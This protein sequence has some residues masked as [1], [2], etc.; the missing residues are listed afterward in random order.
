MR[1]TH[2][3][4]SRFLVAVLIALLLGPLVGLAPAAKSVRAA[5]SA[6]PNEEIV[7]IDPN[8][9]IRVLDP[10]GGEPRVQWYSPTGSW[11]DAC[12]GD[13]NDDG[14]LEI[15]S[16]G[17]TSTG[18]TKIAVFDPV[19]AS[20]T[21]VPDQ[22]IPL[23][24][25]IPWDTFYEN[26]IAGTPQI[27]SCGD[28]DAG[29]PGDEFLYSYKGAG[30]TNVVVMNAA[31]LDSSTGKPTGRDWKVHLEFND[32]DADREW[33]FARSGDVN[34]TG[35][36]EAILVDSQNALT[37]FDVFD[38]DQNFLRID[39]KNSDSENIRKVAVG[40]IIEGGGDEIAEIRSG[41]PGSDALKVY[42]WDSTDYELNTDEAWAFSPQP[43]YVFLADLSGN[44]D[45][46]VL[47]LRKHPDD[48]GAR[49]IMLDKWGDDQK[50]QL[51][52][53]ESLDD[54]EGGAE[55]E[56]KLGAGG[57]VDGDGRDEI[58]IA[59]SSRI[60]IF[61]DPHP[62]GSV[63]S[64]S[65]TEVLRE[66]NN[67]TLLVGDL[68]SQGFIRGPVFGT[69]VSLVS[70]SVPVGTSVQAGSFTISNIGSGSPV[71]FSIATSLPNWVR[72]SPMS[73]VTPQ[74]VTVTFDATN[75][76]VGTKSYMLQIT[77]SA[78][79]VNKPY[80]IDLEMT[81]ASAALTPQPSA[82]NF[83]YFPCSPPVTDT[84]QMEV[85]VKGTMGL[86]FQAVVIGVP[87]S[88]AAGTANIEG[89]ISG[90]EVTPDGSVI[91][92]NNAGSSTTYPAAPTVSASA[93]VT[94]IVWPNDVAWITQASSVTNTVPAGVT[95]SVDPTMFG[96][97]FSKE[98][99]VLV[100]VA[101]TRAGSPPDN[102]AIVPIM[103]MCSQDRVLAPTL[104]R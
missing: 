37:R 67:D 60:I 49:L 2:I 9:V 85:D 99:A 18:N 44:G 62:G 29:I 72:V 103:M 19:I 13:V 5:T 8:G 104:R 102:V 86:N 6:D 75:E 54:I 80:N 69:D 26:E 84:M 51:E 68:D 58:I 14:D 79:V 41:K 57:D 38:V 23:D 32:G 25:G 61:R 34:D 63:G 12:L 20:G 74:K 15:V 36:D 98:H 78:E 17:K 100:L 4:R 93:V 33:R 28:F 73:G 1:K 82:A 47:F 22:T 101:D 55:N 53:E 56:F 10:Y 31:S 89:T 59:S 7:Y 52:I 92:Y 90:G 48:N 91:L 35:S 64:G 88:S 70:A 46:E 71:D 3:G 77:S 96:A 97:D 16:I 40:Q 94:D 76:S 43:E 27:V 65:R 39:G 42:K 24:D 87:E 95:L 30:G 81:V 83:I 21:V 50:N 66:T 11:K 45:K